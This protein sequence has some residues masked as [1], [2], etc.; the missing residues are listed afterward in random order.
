[1]DNKALSLQQLSTGIFFG[2]KHLLDSLLSDL[3]CSAR[4]HIIDGTLESG[5]NREVCRYVGKPLIY[6]VEEPQQLYSFDLDEF[7]N[8]KFDFV[9][10]CS[11][12]SL[13]RLKERY[14]SFNKHATLSNI[15]YLMEML[16][17]AESI[18]Q[19]AVN[20]EPTA[21]YATSE[22]AWLY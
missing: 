7:H 17:A 19:Y 9:M 10:Y 4:F 2:K 1:M 5:I 15:H 22:G 18:L 12:V 11:E 3:N 20:N 6:R 16:F 21:G 8:I 14:L 13:N